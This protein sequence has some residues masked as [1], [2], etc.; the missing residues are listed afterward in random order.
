MDNSI[1]RYPVTPV[2]FT[3][4]QVSDDFWSPRIRTHLDVTIPYNFKMMEETGR[5]ANF[6]VASG[7]KEGQSD[8]LTPC[9]S[10]SDVYKVIEGA[11][12][13][14]MIEPDPKLA[15]SLPSYTR[16]GAE[17]SRSRRLV[18]VCEHKPREGCPAA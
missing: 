5:I 10:D 11:S 12:Y 7:S 9:W 3:G 6:E 4:V 13:S 2:N 18:P 17:S 8:S 16:M 1:Y 15:E 14:L